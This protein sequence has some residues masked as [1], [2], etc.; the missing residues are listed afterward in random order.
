MKYLFKGIWFIITWGIIVYINIFSFLWHLDFKHKHYYGEYFLT[1]DDINTLS[2][3]YQLDRLLN[4][5]RIK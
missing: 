2:Q 3:K 1:I 4:Y 5:F